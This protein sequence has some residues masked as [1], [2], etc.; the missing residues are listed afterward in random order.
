MIL[1][2]KWHISFLWAKF[3]VDVETG[4]ETSGTLHSK[5]NK[6]SAV[7][8]KIGV[9]SLKLLVQLIILRKIKYG[10]LNC[11]IYKVVY[12]WQK[13]RKKIKYRQVLWGQTPYCSTIFFPRVYYIWRGTHSIPTN[14]LYVIVISHLYWQAGVLKKSGSFEK[15]EA[16]AKRL[17]SCKT[18]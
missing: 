1:E 17:Q 6:H 3:F 15:W 13:A 5:W 16:E 2:Q 4:L 7:V 18:R 8:W 11:G 12:V 14:F 9:Y 10:V